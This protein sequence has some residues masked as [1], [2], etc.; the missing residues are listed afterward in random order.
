MRPIARWIIGGA[1]VLA[2]VLWLVGCTPGDAVDSPGYVSGDGT[3]TIFD[4][5][6]ALTLTGTS[7]AGDPVDT[8]DFKGQVVVLSYWAAT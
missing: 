5:G 7:F 8:S 1:L 2:I 6:T 4:D 3:V